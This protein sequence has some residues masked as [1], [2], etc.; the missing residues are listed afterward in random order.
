MVRVAITIGDP[1]GIGPEISIKTL[2]SAD[3][4]EVDVKLIGGMDVLT[5]CAMTLG[6]GLP[7]RSHVVDVPVPGAEQVEPGTVTA[8]GGRAS[9]AYIER[10]CEL[11]KAGQIDAIVTAPINKESLRV[12]QCPHIGHTEILAATFGVTQPLTLF[13][14]D[15]LKVFFLSRHLSLREAIDYATRERVLDM[16]RL[17]HGAMAQLGYASP[18]IA[19]AAMNPHASDGGQFGNEEADHL[20]PAV[21]AARREGID[22]RGPIGADSVFHQGLQ[23]VHDCV[24][25]L[26]HDQGHIATKTRDFYGTISATLGLPVLRTSVDHG[27]AFDIAWQGI[28]NEYSLTKAVHTAVDL[29]RRCA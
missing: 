20:E 10:A 14:T 17:V 9:V 4:G 2:E 1:A 23:G 5:R 12:A 18:S 8:A 3:L 27:T 28:A 21:R 7:D 15:N 25:S 24:L 26:Y 11:A 16:L 29:L 19:V 22:A 6:L 13:I